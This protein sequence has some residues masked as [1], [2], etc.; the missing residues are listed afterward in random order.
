MTTST[1]KKALKTGAFIA[2][3]L[4]SGASSAL[5]LPA[6]SSCTFG[7]G[8]L[9]CYNTQSGAELY[10]A[11]SHDDFISYGV[12]AIN[13]YV[14]MGFGELTPFANG[15][16]SGTI[17]KLFTYNESNQPQ[18]IEGYT[19]PQPN[20]G[21]PTG[22]G[23]GSDAFS[24]DWP[25]SGSFSIAALKAYLGSQTTPVF[26]FDFGE[27]QRTGNYLTVNGYFDVIRAA[28]GSVRFSFDDVVNNQ[29]DLASAV[30]APVDQY[31]FYKDTQACTLTGGETVPSQP[32]QYFCRKAISNVLG[33]GAAEFYAYAA[34]F[35]VNDFADGDILQFHLNM[36]A[37]DSTGEELFL[38]KAVTPPSQVPEPASL[39]LLGLALFA[40]S[41]MRQQHRATL[42]T[43]N[44]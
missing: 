31:I 12:A 29:F 21:T 44:C 30:I 13:E 7:P 8:N 23:S 42:A 10:V 25:V 35:N 5:S 33:N 1:F 36:G 34:L 28:G 39:A 18:V 22:G 11:S 2:A 3:L 40:L 24:G 27:S 19:F 4:A 38:N 6:V 26:G 41:R 20:D 32:D 37:L 17:L 14:A 9:L 15:L 43:A 16:G